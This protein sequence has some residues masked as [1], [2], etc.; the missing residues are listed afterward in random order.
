[1]GS[2]FIKAKQAVCSAMCLAHPG[3]TAHLSLAVNTSNSH[4]EEVL[5][6]QTTSRLQP[7]AFFSAKLSPA[8]QYWYSAFGRKLLAAYLAVRHFHF[9]LEAR[10]FH[11]LTDYQWVTAAGLLQRQAVTSRAVLA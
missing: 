10:V 3:P 7:L 4:V 5:Q 11:I 1:M 6:Q 9:L 2:A 8:E